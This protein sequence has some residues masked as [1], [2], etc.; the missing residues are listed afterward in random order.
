MKSKTKKLAFWFDKVES[1][2][3]GFIVNE[4]IIMNEDH[5]FLFELCNMSNE[6]RYSTMVLLSKHTNAKE[7]LSGFFA[8]D[9]WKKHIS[10]AS[11][12]EFNKEKNKK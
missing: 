4:K 9:K 12:S 6:W 11:I 5:F 8:Y 2:G 7:L 10:T 1:N 3:K